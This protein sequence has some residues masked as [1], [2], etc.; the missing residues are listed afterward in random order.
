MIRVTAI[1]VAVGLLQAGNSSLLLK[2]DDP[3]W[4]RPAPERFRVDLETNKGGIGI[5]VVREWAP[6]GADRFYNLVRH[7]YYD[8]ARFFRVISG[9]WA[10]FGINGDPAVSKMW[11][12]RTMPDE[13]RVTSNVR[14]TIAYAFKDPNGRTT[15]VFFNLRDNTAT[16]DVEPFVPFGRVVEGMDVVDRLNGEYGERAGGGIRRGQQDPLF[17]GGNEYLRRE[18]PRLDYIYRARIV[19]AH[20]TTGGI[21]ENEH[22][23]RP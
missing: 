20:G 6:I 18:F 14:G 2:P 21:Q 7:G 8:G 17:N 11:R 22:V 19:A 10:Q 12:T 9:Q 1:L 3:E 15:Q 5:D 4:S 23:H 16:H 13:P